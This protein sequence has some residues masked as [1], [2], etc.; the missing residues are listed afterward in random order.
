MRLN[1][2][3]TPRGGL[4][5]AHRARGRRVRVKPRVRVAFPESGFG[6][7]SASALPGSGSD[8]PCRVRVRIGLAG[9]GPDSDWFRQGGIRIGF[10]G[11]FSD[12]DRVLHHGTGAGSV[13]KRPAGL[14]AHYQSPSLVGGMLSSLPNTITAL[15]GRARQTSGRRQNRYFI[16]PSDTA[17]KHSMMRDAPEEPGG[18]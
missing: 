9:P 15:Y 5:R 1:A 12:S 3:G 11:S 10:A 8:R 17:Q 14:I 6:P 18:R 4:D 2:N 16:S 7:K 13:L